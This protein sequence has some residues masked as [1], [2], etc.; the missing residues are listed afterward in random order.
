MSVITSTSGSAP[1][2]TEAVRDAYGAKQL[3][4]SSRFLGQQ[5]AVAVGAGDTI[6][7]NYIEFGPTM[8]GDHDE[9]ILDDG[10]SSPTI[11][12]N[13]LLNPNGQTSTLSLFTEFGSNRNLL[14]QDNLLAGGGFT[15][16]RGD[17]A[18]DNAGKPARASKVSFMDNVFWEKSFPTVGQYGPGRAYNPAGG[19]QW[20]GNVYM[21]AD[22]TLTT[23]QVPQPPLDGQ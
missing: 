21:L 18:A 20:T 8:R 9:D 17:G 15:Y 6:R 7:D 11:E 22:G 13:T 1:Y 2:A 5:L 10:T 19:G 4:T 3:I 23:R 14:I 12:H 16:Y